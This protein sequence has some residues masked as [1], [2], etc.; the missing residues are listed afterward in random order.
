VNRR[1]LALP[2]LLGLAL[3]P[4]AAGAALGPRYGGELAVAVAELPESLEPGVPRGAA[5]G[6]LAALV[7]ETLVAGG[8]DGVPVP[9]LAR[10]WASG[11]GG[12]EWTLRLAEGAAFHDG[13]PVTAIEAARSLRRFLRADSASAARFA[14]HLEGGPAYR[15]RSTEDTPGLSILDETRLTIRLAEPVPLPLAPLSA[16]AAAITSSSGAGA[17]PFAPAS[18]L[19]AK[20]RSLTAFAAHLAGRPY[21]DQLRLLPAP[22]PQ[23]LEAA[24]S[25]G[26]LG[27][28]PRVGPAPHAWLAS[29][30]LI[31]DP[32]QPPFDRLP[33]RSA[34][35][36]A[37]TTPD[38]LG[39]LLPGAAGS[40]SLLPP[41]L[42]PP[43]GLPALPTPGPLAGEAVMA[44]SR[45]VPPL[46]SQR[47]VAYLLEA[48]LRV[49]A[50]PQSPREA[51]RARAQLR[52]VLAKPEVAEA[53]LAL[54]ELAS[55]APPV[56]GAQEALLAAEG[57]FSLDRRQLHLH[58]AEA[59]L[60][61]DF[62]LIPLAAVPL[63]YAAR[64]GLHGVALDPRG[65]LLLEDAWL[66]P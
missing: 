21:L 58:R 66:D 18:F 24:L 54:G 47:V 6:L 39:Q 2:A 56:P 8:P 59:A 4:W 9:R 55:L 42:L 20:S 51:E 25:A 33:A 41:S 35:A 19:P 46:L 50:R 5:E 22:E 26:R 32:A 34:L 63:S 31:V 10:G 37:L 13:K 45:E 7:H 1:T 48:G 3:I 36:A 29:L 60:R 30:L 14:R 52:L 65:R 38:L 27:L 57:E 53:G 17:G 23:G 40:R 15:A 28:H 16:T 49:T 62:T 44:V 43:L 64:P 11:A 12:R 61:G